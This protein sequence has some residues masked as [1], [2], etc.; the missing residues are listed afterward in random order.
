MQSGQK[1]KN[2]LENKIGKVELSISA[3]DTAWAARVTSASGDIVFPQSLDW[4]K[5]NQLEDG[6]WGVTTPEYYHDRII[7]TLASVIAIFERE[8]S[9]E[10]VTRGTKYINHSL[11]KLEED[12]QITIGFEML[13]P[14]LL[15]QA[16][17]LGIGLD[18]SHSIILNYKKLRAKKL[19]LIPKESLYL[20]KS[21]LGYSLEFLETEENVDY[22]GLTVQQED[23]G[24]CM[25]S[26]AATAFLLKHLPHNTAAKNYL[27]NIYNLY[28]GGFV[29]FYPID[30][31]ER[32]WTLSYLLDLELF[33]TFQQSIDGHLDYIAKSWQDTGVSCSRHFSAINL[34]DTS[35]AFKVLASQGYNPDPSVF[36]QFEH[37]DTYIGFKGE[38]HPGVS[39]IANLAAAVA[40]LGKSHSL[41]KKVFKITADVLSSP[42]TD[43]WNI[44]PY[45]AIS[46]LPVEFL[47][48]EPELRSQ[49]ETFL[50]STQNEDGGWGNKKSNLQD[51]NYALLLAYKLTKAGAA[52]MNDLTEKGKHALATEDLTITPN[53]IAKSLYYPKTIEDALRLMHINS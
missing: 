14:S 28:N 22:E 26:P 34:D 1:L 30:I 42:K 13:F 51:T 32:T 9:T 48:E 38:S 41:T 53:W 24:S 8:G 39:H 29:C 11:S 33:G 47:E 16:E 43:K 12:E 31:F 23:D 37:D 7:S 21:S 35:V 18:Y 46:R 36:K 27:D 44:S 3:Y 2:L 15:I 4:L 6:S 20:Q 40:E 52:G 5:N 10:E 19:G 25:S 49:Y 45:Y 50:K 17:K